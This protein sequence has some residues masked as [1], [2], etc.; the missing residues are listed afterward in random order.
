MTLL[1]LVLSLDRTPLAAVELDQPPHHEQ[2]GDVFLAAEG[3]QHA[4][5]HGA[6][7]GGGGSA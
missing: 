4:A 7:P 6:D 5:E 3:A 1:R 2:L